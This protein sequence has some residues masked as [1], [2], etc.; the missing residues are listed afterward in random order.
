MPTQVGKK[1]VMLAAFFKEKVTI[2]TI[3]QKCY[4]QNFDWVH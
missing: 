1:T 3:P 2:W 4:E